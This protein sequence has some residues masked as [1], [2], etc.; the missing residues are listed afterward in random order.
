M[1][2]CAR[3]FELPGLISSRRASIAVIWSFIT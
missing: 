3:I 2:N 1:V